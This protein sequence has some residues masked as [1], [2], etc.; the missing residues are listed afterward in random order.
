MSNI[1]FINLSS[2]S[3]G[4]YEKRA[5][6]FLRSSPDL[7][8]LNI[9][10]SC[11][12]GKPFG[13]IVYREYK[14]DTSIV[15]L[16]ETLLYVYNEFLEDLEYN[17]NK[18][19]D[20]YSY[21]Y[22]NY[23]TAYDDAVKK[24]IFEIVKEDIDAIVSKFASQDNF[25]DKCCSCVL[26]LNKKHN[27]GKTFLKMNIKRDGWKYFN[28]ML[29]SYIY[30][31]IINITGNVLFNSFNQLIKDGKIKKLDL[32]K[33]S[34]LKKL[35]C[36]IE[37]EKNEV[38]KL[39]LTFLS[40]LYETDL[41][42]YKSFLIHYINFKPNHFLIEL[43][44][45]LKNRIELDCAKVKDLELTLKRF[46]SIKNVISFSKSKMQMII[47]Y[48]KNSSYYPAAEKK[49]KDRFG[50]Y[51]CDV[52][53]LMKYYSRYNETI[54]LFEQFYNLLDSKLIYMLKEEIDKVLNDD[55]LKQFM[56]CL[57]NKTDYN[58]KFNLEF[59]YN[60]LGF[61]KEDSKKEL[62]FILYFYSYYSNLLK[63]KEI[64]VDLKLEKTILKCND[65]FDKYL[66]NKF[67]KAAK[68]DIKGNIELLLFLD[69]E[70]YCHY[71]CLIKELDNFNIYFAI[72]EE[73]KKL[74]DLLFEILKNTSM[75][76]Q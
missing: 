58:E 13:Y 16:F 46:K 42:L 60:F 34:E 75:H 54:N 33:S 52:L 44:E 43:K 5:N 61:E 23:F 28:E 56:A 32:D 62:K 71:N 30:Y 65:I 53:E 11:A 4:D 20:N 72:L 73:R 74:S 24:I 10:I 26:E 25:I 31:N 35:K 3:K 67:K 18:E 40:H 15:P 51:K 55:I 66:D 39:Y 41:N 22:M 21:K 19:E 37:T 29:Y 36:D 50:E 8:I 27:F 64:K 47:D 38:F 12:L 49:L 63:N 2:P 1:L 14:E 45:V 70:M 69:K 17:L 6:A 76:K 59:V 48:F 7:E 68:E 57:A 9:R